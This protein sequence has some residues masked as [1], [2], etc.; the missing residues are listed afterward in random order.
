MD[1]FLLEQFMLWNGS[2]NTACCLIQH[3]ENNSFSVVA[4]NSALSETL[5][6]AVDFASLEN[7]SGITHYLQSVFENG[8][9]NLQVQHPQS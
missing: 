1:K 7:F 9:F 5:N 3:H 6:N 4:F 2:I 8:G